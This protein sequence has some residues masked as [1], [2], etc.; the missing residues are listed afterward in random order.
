MISEK[1]DKSD[2]VNIYLR[3]SFDSDMAIILPSPVKS[4]KATFSIIN[5][6]M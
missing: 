1:C 3:L 2:T 5:I 4:G 6:E